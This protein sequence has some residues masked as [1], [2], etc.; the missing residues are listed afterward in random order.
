M[1]WTQVVSVI[2]LQANLS[3][4]DN[5]D[6]F[7]PFNFDDHRNSVITNDMTI[8][9]EQNLIEFD[10]FSIFSRLCSNVEYPGPWI[11]SE[12]IEP[13]PNSPF[14]IKLS[15]IFCFSV[16]CCRRFFLTFFFSS[17]SWL[18]PPKVVTRGLSVLETT[19]KK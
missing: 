1:R 16:F 2:L 11:F 8:N 10:R 18:L 6:I 4:F 13:N 7:S 17:S 9:V 5:F 12:D 15:S 3:I 14:S 19:I